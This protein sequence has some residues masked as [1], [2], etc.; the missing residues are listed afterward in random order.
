MPKKGPPKIAREPATA[1]APRL[2]ANPDSYLEMSPVWRFGAFD[3]DGP[4]GVA[5][6]AGRPWRKHLEQ[7]LAS[8]ETMTWDEIL[9]ASGGKGQGKGTNSH[10]LA[11]DRLARAAQKRLEERQVTADEIFSLRLD[12]CTRVYGVREVNCLSIVF[13]DP[14]HCN[15]DGSA[16]YAWGRS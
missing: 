10:S 4:W 3:W 2:G 6:C 15:R 16:A 7:H 12:N 14:N 13:F 5:A 9:R 1:G 8:F 11:R